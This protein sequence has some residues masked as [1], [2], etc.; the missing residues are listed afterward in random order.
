VPAAI[1]FLDWTTA[2]IPCGAVDLDQLV[3]NGNTLR[4]SIEPTAGG[5]SA[6]DW[7]PV[8]PDWHSGR[9]GAAAAGINSWV[10]L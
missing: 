2:Q 9:D 1:G 10:A 5:G 7:L 4:G 8:D 3:C 6:P